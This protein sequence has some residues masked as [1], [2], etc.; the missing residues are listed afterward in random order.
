MIQMG[1]YI[2]WILFSA[3]PDEGIFVSSSNSNQKLMVD[4][5]FYVDTLDTENFKNIATIMKSSS[6]TEE[7]ACYF[8]EV[9]FNRYVTL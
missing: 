2:C 6:I 9:L 7:L 4:L 3:A 8:V 5:M 1:E